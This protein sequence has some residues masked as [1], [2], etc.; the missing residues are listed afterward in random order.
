MVAQKLS[1]DNHEIIIVNDGSTDGTREQLNRLS[2]LNKM[3]NVI[4][5][6]RN[7]GI[8]EALL[9]GYSNAKNENI[10]AVPADGQF[11]LE[12]LLPHSVI[13]PKNFISFHREI[14][15]A[16]SSYRTFFSFMN[17]KI[18]QHILGLKIKDVNWVK[19]YKLEELKKI[20]L[21]MHSSLIET[22]ICAKLLIN[23][24]NMIEI[25]SSYNTRIAGKVKGSSPRELF[26]ISKE[27]FRLIKI[28][29][30]FKNA[31]KKQLKY[32]MK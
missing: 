21:Q 14:K 22:E 28:I 16:Y 24:N 20:N 6:T 4:N 27:L 3:I 17:R 26:R 31:L 29:T 12:E 8:G 15:T 5:H 32:E 1:P 9:S 25:P 23:S 30:R 13:P 11:N 7:L 2:S 19:I 18:N 10:S